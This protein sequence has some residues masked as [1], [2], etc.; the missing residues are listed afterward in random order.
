MMWTG[1]KQELLAFLE[2]LDK[3]HKT[4]KFEHNISRINISFLDTLI[5]KDKNNALQTTFY[6]KPLISS[7][8]CIHI[9]TI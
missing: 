5:Y 1:T 9:Q 6:Q 8:I 4:I 3:K 2:N 7:P